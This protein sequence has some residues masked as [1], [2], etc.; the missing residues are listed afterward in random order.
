MARVPKDWKMVYM[1]SI[2]KKGNKDDC[3]NY[4]EI[5]L[6]STINRLYGRVLWDLIEAEF[7]EEE[8][9]CGFRGGRS[10]TDNVFVMKQIR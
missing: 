7:E 4:R 5:S 2:H 9:Q 8:E 6:T 1:S 3:N 10:C